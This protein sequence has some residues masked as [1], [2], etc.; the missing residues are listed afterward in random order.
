MTYFLYSPS[1][2]GESE[3]HN[4]QREKKG[5]KIDVQNKKQPTHCLVDNEIYESINNP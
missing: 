1:Q 3:Q 2:K 4:H 5:Q